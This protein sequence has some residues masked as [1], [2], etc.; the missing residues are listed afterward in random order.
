MG[1]IIKYMDVL[2]Y[3]RIFNVWTY[4]WTYYYMDA[5]FNNT[6]MDKSNLVFANRFLF[7]NFLEFLHYRIKFL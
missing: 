3:G 1:R 5:L 6:S 2:L 7:S 4:V